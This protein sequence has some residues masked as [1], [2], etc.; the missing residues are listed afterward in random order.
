MGLYGFETS[1]HLVVIEGENSRYGKDIVCPTPKR[2][3]FLILLFLKHNILSL[4]GFG[5]AF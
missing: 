1:V 2:N 3:S 5:L 4:L